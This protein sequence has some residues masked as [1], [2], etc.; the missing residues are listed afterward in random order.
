MGKSL[1]S[2]RAG[3]RAQACFVRSELNTGAASLGTAPRDG[4]SSVEPQTSGQTT[5][6]IGGELS[7]ISHCS[8]LRN[9]FDISALAQ[10]PERIGRQRSTDAPFLEA[11][12]DVRPERGAQ[13]LLRFQ[14]SAGCLQFRELLAINQSCL[15]KQLLR[16]TNRLDHGFHRGF[17]D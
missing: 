15:E 7:S 14:D 17:E 9:A 5:S 2:A 10:G 16:D 12:S 8:F 13:A 6:G 11:R 3:W 1:G 4:G